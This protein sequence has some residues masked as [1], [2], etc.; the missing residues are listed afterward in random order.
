MTELFPTSGSDGREH[1]QMLCKIPEH[2]NENKDLKTSFSEVSC[3]IQVPRICG[4]PQGSALEPGFFF[5]P[6]IFSS[7]FLL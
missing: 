2:S 4:V 3:L 5:P 1:R 6:Q 7:P